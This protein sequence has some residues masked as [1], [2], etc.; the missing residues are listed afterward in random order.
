MN[1]FTYRYA[2][3]L[4]NGDYY[5]RPTTRLWASLGM[6]DLVADEPIMTFTSRDAA[7]QMMQELARQTAALGM[8]FTGRIVTSMCT[9]FTD[10]DDPFGEFAAEVDQWLRSQG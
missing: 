6:A 8:T 2:I 7:E 10:S 9:P 5:R 1:G 4:P 3:V